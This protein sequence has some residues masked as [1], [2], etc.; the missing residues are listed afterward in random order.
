MVEVD[1][2]AG[3]NSTSVSVEVL[4]TRAVGDVSGGVSMRISNR[5]YQHWWPGTERG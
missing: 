3:K 5:T 2:P 1:E 4:V